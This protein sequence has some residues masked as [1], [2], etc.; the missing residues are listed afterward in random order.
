MIN[1]VNIL[2]EKVEAKGGLKKAAREYVKNKL[3]SAFGFDVFGAAHEVFETHVK[4]PARM[5]MAST[6]PVV[7]F[8]ESYVTAAIN[9]LPA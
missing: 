4:Q 3:S 6:N 2:Q 8:T 7:S 9:V 1:S 5:V